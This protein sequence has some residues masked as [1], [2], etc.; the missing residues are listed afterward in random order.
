MKKKK[1]KSTSRIHFTFQFELKWE[2][3]KFNK[4][5]RFRP[6][7]GFFLFP[8]GFPESHPGSFLAASCE[9]GL[10]LLGAFEREI[11]DLCFGGTAGVLQVVVPHDSSKIARTSLMWPYDTWAGKRSFIADNLL[12]SERKRKWKSNETA[13]SY[14]CITFGHN[15]SWRKTQKENVTN[16]LDLIDTSDRIRSGVGI[17]SS[18]NLPLQCE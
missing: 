17:G 3:S 8:P 14:Y 13:M 6:Q 9:E 1:K 11:K 18:R 10:E 15:Q 16:L 7:K 12:M 5:I 4:Q 2:G